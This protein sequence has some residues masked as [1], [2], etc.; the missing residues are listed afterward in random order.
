MNTKKLMNLINMGV[1]LLISLIV[2]TIAGV[3]L[4]NSDFSKNNVRIIGSIGLVVFIVG[5]CQLIFNKIRFKY[6]Y[7]RLWGGVLIVSCIFL[8]IPYNLNMINEV[9]TVANNYDRVKINKEKDIIFDMDTE[10]MESI[11]KKYQF[12]TFEN[13]ISKLELEDKDEIKFYYD[14]DKSKES[15]DFGYEVIKNYHDEIN[16]IFKLDDSIN[17]EVIILENLNTAGVYSSSVGGFVNRLNNK[18][19]MKSK[20]SLEFISEEE[21]AETLKYLGF[22]PEETLNFDVALVHEYTHKLT[23]DLFGRYKID[24]FNIPVWFYEGLAVYSE[25]LYLKQDMA[26]SAMRFKNIKDDSSFSGANSRQH[27]EIAGVFVNYLIQ[28]Y[29]D[30]IIIDIVKNIEDE[31]DIYMAIKKITNKTFD[32]LI[33]NIYL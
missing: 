27:Y 26:Q 6:L 32:E 24:N 20:H 9:I 8:F 19:Y 15:I 21:K 31:I 18:I 33:E 2:T 23:N 13:H 4:F 17:T 3:L 11:F 12:A 22:I 29:G 16:S 1:Y 28:T 5:V 30:N 14:N 10:Y 7:G 25:N